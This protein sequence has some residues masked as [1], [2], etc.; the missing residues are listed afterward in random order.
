MVKRVFGAGSGVHV[1]S[2]P[3]VHVPSVVGLVVILW[4]CILVVSGLRAVY[5]DFLVL[6]CIPNESAHEL[7]NNPEQILHV[8]VVFCR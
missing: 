1:P 3:L 8:L 2:M 6:S 4:G 5:S 7:T